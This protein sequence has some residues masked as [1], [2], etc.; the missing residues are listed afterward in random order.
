MSHASGRCVFDSDGLV[1]HFEYDGTTDQCISHLYATYAEMDA[2]WRKGEWLVCN[3]GRDEPVKLDVNYAPPNVEC[4][5]ACRHCMAITKDGHRYVEPDR[6]DW[7]SVF[8]TEKK[9]G[10]LGKESL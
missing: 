10:N 2:N 5:R 3:C 6:T 4:G 9:E 7:M 8:A 1:L